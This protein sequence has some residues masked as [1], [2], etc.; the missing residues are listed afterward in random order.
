MPIASGSILPDDRFFER[1]WREFKPPPDLVVQQRGF[2]LEQRPGRGGYDMLGDVELA[3]PSGNRT[4]LIVAHREHVK[5]GELPKIKQRLRNAIDWRRRADPSDTGLARA[6]VALATEVASPSLRDACQ[7]EW[8]GLLDLTGTAIIHDG[9]LF[10]HVEG[11]TPVRKHVRVPYFQGAAT[12]VLRCLLDAATQE[13]KNWSTEAMAAA[14][15]LS[16]PYVWRVLRSLEDAGYVWR[17]SPRTGFLLRDAPALL[18]AWL[19][20]GAKTWATAEDFNLRSIDQKS[21]LPVEDA[22]RR[23]GQPFAWTLAAATDDHFV[24]GLPAGI[25]LT[26]SRLFVETLR[27]RRVTPSNIM[28]LRPSPECATRLGGVFMREGSVPLPQLILDFH[29]LG[30]RATDQAEHLFQK[31]TSQIVISHA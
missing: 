3:A 18:R 27:P 8:L 24:F 25:Y 16:L 15:E 26:D 31:W 28:V 21:L 6:V 4:R 23:A 10:L 20:A 30:G 2:L 19:K 12:R 14:T 22:L 17:R 7:R 9:P 1:F 13:P 29:A 5:A 11:T